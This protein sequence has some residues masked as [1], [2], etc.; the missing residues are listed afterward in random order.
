MFAMLLQVRVPCFIALESFYRYDLLIDLFAVMTP[1]TYPRAMPMASR[2]SVSDRLWVLVDGSV[3]AATYEGVC[4]SVVAL[5]LLAR[6]LRV[7]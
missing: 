2:Q 7:Y 3:C 5:P 1:A 6:L 4:C